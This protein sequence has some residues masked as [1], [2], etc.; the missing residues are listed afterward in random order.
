[1][2]EMTSPALQAVALEAAAESGS[3]AP[4]TE[5]EGSLLAT[6]LPWQRV[7]VYVWEVPV[8]ITHWAAVITV[9][10]L[11][12]TGA[13]IAD[14]FV[15]PA[16]DFVMQTMRFIH[17]VAAYVFLA[18]GVLRTYWLFAGNEFSNWRAFIPTTRRHWAEFRGQTAWYLFLRRDLPPILGHNALA[19][20]TYM[21]IFF[22]F[23]T[24]TITGFA[25]ESVHGGLAAQLWGWLPA[26]IGISTVRIVHHL[27]MWVILAFMIHHVYSAIMVDH[28]ERNGLMSS[29]FA[30]YKF[31]TR[32]DI[33][34]ARD[35]GMEVQER[36]N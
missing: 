20:G 7:R 11:T 8:R 21:V 31:V 25:L 34:N 3:E 1:M 16:T 33:Q 28:W 14:P 15:V 10:I 17:M 18:S 32:R 6:Q 22:L 29:I 27:I 26:L 23:L 12:V 5:E 30:G 9:M 36:S 19:A 2:A 4:L 24:Q 13:Y 35:G